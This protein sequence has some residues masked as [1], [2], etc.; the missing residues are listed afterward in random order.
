MKPTRNRL[1]RALGVTV[2]R[3]G[4]LASEG[5]PCDSIAGARAWRREQERHPLRMRMKPGDG[6]PDGTT[7]ANASTID[8]IAGELAKAPDY[9]TAKTLSEKLSGLRLAE[10]L[11]RDIKVVVPVE[12]VRKSD[13]RV[14]YACRVAIDRFVADAAPVIVGLDAP[15]I[16]KALMEHGHRL[17]DRLADPS[18]ECWPSTEREPY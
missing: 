10:R 11:L 6:I 9:A 5:M 16:H 17:L 15:R 2:R 1:A 12:E 4:Q 18:S 14:A 3:I 8:E 7:A 13:A